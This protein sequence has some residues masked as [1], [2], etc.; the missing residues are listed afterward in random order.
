MCYFAPLFPTVSVQLTS[1]VLMIRPVSFGY[2][3]E[4]AVNNHYQV[5]TESMDRSEVQKLAQLEFDGLVDKLR[6]KGISVSV[7]ED[8][9][10]P[11]TPDSI[12]PNNWVSFHEDGQTVLYPMF[13]KNRRAERRPDVLENLERDDETI[14]DLSNYEG[15]H[16]FLEGTGSMVLDRKNKVAY[17]CLSERTYANLLRNWAKEMGYS[18]CAFQATQKVNGIEK[19]IYHT[20][21]MMSV[22]EDLAVI[23]TGV[24]REE[25]ERNRV[26]KSLESTDHQVIEISENQINHFAGNMLQVANESGQ[27]FMVMST[28]AFKSLTQEQI[29]AIQMNSAILHSPLNT[30]ERLGGGSARCMLAE[31]F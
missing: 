23:C 30:I 14:L 6:S 24:I 26:L 2:N 25:Q 17:A 21:V 27:R 15:E 9:L 5:S 13:A 4:T 20:N 10:Q 1:H 22:G 8:T 3:A 18:I 7:V 11:P 29:L 28:Q 16:R 12:F 31:V 19:P